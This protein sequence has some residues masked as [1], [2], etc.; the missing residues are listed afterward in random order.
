LPELV[1][2]VDGEINLPT[3]ITFKWKKATDLDGDFVT[4]KICLRKGND[5]F[6]DSDCNAVLQQSAH[7]SP[8]NKVGA[9]H[10]SPLPIGGAFGFLLGAVLIGNPRGRRRLF[11]LFAILIVTSSLLTACT[12]LPGGIEPEKISHT[13]SDLTPNTTYFWKVVAED[14]K[15]GAAESTVRSFTTKP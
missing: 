15:G 6:T 5:H 12:D 10:E 9:I 3:S 11:G 4:Y 1:S 13:V 2:P 8:R 7:Q 14:S